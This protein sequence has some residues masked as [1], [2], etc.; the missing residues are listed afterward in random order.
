MIYHLLFFLLAACC[1]VR[2]YTKPSQKN[3]LL[4]ASACLI[5]LF[6][7]LRWRTGTDWLPYEEFFRSCISHP[8]SFEFEFGYAFLNRAVRS[9]TDSYTVFLFVECGLT[10]FFWSLFAREMNTQSPCVILLSLF[11]AGVFPIRYTLAAAIILCSYIYILQRRLVPFLLMV[12]LAFSIHRTAIVF[13]PVYFVATR[14]YSFKSLLL[15]YAVAVSLGFFIDFVFGNLLQMASL[16][17]EHMNSTVQEKMNA[18]MSQEVSD[19]HQMTPLRI[20]LSLLN[21]TL[22][23]FFFGYFRKKFFASDALFN[24]L[25]N[26]YVLGLC[27]NRLFIQALPELNRL[28]ALFAGGFTVMLVMIIA[29]YKQQTR[30]V[31]TMLLLV[32]TYTIYCRVIYG[33]YEDLFIPYM[34]VFDGSQRICV[35]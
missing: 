3:F 7:A 1:V 34:S 27:F 4:F 11:V 29:R 15:L 14:H 5:V 13:A 24:M 20:A 25:F 21:S 10:V 2:L 18:Y 9:V 35:Y 31:L 30:L 32:Y 26:L 6:Q 17:Y 12:F 19:A 28:T 8:D 23:L 16:A 33:T 22:F